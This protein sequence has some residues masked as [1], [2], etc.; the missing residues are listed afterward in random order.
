MKTLNDEILNR[1][2][3]SAKPASCIYCDGTGD[4]HDAIGEWSGTCTCPAGKSAQGNRKPAQAEGEVTDA[5]DLWKIA[6]GA[7]DETA[8][9]NESIRDAWQRVVDKVIEASQKGAP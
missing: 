5:C 3:T 8:N 6:Q 1:A 9:K 7:W 4:V 2:A